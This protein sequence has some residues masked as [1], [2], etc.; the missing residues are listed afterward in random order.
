[1]P[2][3]SPKIS[4]CSYTYND[5][6]LLRGLLESVATWTMQPDEVVLVD[7]GS[8]IPFVL[9]PEETAGLPARCIRLPE[10]RGFTVAKHTCISAATGDIIVAVD[11]DSRLYPNFLECAAQQLSDP[12]IGMMSGCIGLTLSKDILSSYLNVF[13]DRVYAEEPKDMDFLCG[14]GFALRREVW[15]EV[16][17]FGGYDGRTCE[18]HYLS[19]IIRE[20]GYR[21]RLDSR[22]HV[23]HARRLTRHAFCQRIWKWCGEAWLRELRPG[24]PL[25][26]HF[27]LWFLN[28]ILERCAT[29][30]P[31][32]PQE[33]LYLELLQI[34]FLASCF[35]NSLGTPDTLGAPG[36][37]C[38]SG[39]ISFNSGRAMQEVL[40]QKLAPYPKL[41]ALLKADLL[42]AGLPPQGALPQGQDD[43][44]NGLGL[45]REWEPVFAFLD[46]FAAGGI[47]QWLEET[48]MRLILED[49]A[50]L[51]ADY[52]TYAEGW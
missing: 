39:R 1:M 23:F 9:R 29:I 14:A 49:E 10:N 4:L 22:T 45:R 19:H 41:R 43:P 25:P 28:P 21:L 8:T 32:F 18:D 50:R 3:T 37:S 24:I 26:G 46:T 30:I 5:A 2:A 20:R 35:C 15:E 36:A 42:R 52:S 40:W 38:T 51:D 6:R 47:L 12:S 16:G 17:G 31:R 33:W 27:Q 48:G 7:D 34:A 44:Q 13:G 11:C